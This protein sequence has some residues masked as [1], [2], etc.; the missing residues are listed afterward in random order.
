MPLRFGLPLRE[1]AAAGYASVN[2][3]RAL[4]GVMR[5]DLTI[6]D[7]LRAAGRIALGGAAVAVAFSV[8]WST[9]GDRPGRAPPASGEGAPAAAP[10]PAWI[11]LPDAAPAY[12]LRRD[13]VFPSEASFYSVRRNVAGG[14][15]LDQM[16]FGAPGDGPSLRL[17]IYRPL[18]EPRGGVSFWLEMARRAGEAGLA[19]ERAPP[20]PDTLPT[21]LGVF[22]YGDLVAQAGERA[23]SCG[24]FR[25]VATKPDVTISGLACFGAQPP[26]PAAMRRAVACALEG[27]ALAP[28]E[29]DLALKAFFMGLH[30]AVCPQRLSQHGGG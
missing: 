3:V 27:L 23:V 5:L 16:A 14:G 13:P 8:L 1:D 12:L 6:A 25:L 7:G 10:A 20:V 22:E 17:S 15:R 18:D 21:R 11:E 9:F 28:G 4:V 26:D 29:D 19:L 30:P 24:G 2:A